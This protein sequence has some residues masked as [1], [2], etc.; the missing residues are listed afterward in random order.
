MIEDK[1]FWHNDITST[2]T[3]TLYQYNNKIQP[4]RN[5]NQHQQSYNNMPVIYL[6]V[7]KPYT[8]RAGKCVTVKVWCENEYEHSKL[9]I[10]RIHTFTPPTEGCI[11]VFRGSKGSENYLTLKNGGT[12]SSAKLKCVDVY[13][14]KYDYKNKPLLFVLH[15]ENGG[16]NGVS[17]KY[18]RMSCF[19]Q[20]K[21]RCKGIDELCDYKNDSDILCALVKESDVLSNVLMYDIMQRPTSNGNTCT[22]NC[23]KIQVTKDTNGQDPKLGTDFKR[24]KHQPGSGAK[25]VTKACVTYLCQA[26]LD[27]G[28]A[29]LD[30]VQGKPY[31]CITVY[32][33][34]KA[35]RA[36]TDKCKAP[37]A[38]ACTQGTGEGSA[39]PSPTS[40]G[41]NTC[42][43]A[44]GDGTTDHQEVPLMIAL[45][46]QSNSDSNNTDY[47][48]H[49]R[50]AK[51]G[52]TGS[53]TDQ[54]YWVK[55][56]NNGHENGLKQLLADIGFQTASN[57]L[58][59]S[60]RVQTMIVPLLKRLEFD[61][62]DSVVI[63]LDKKNGSGGYNDTDIT[64]AIK[65][66]QTGGKN[67]T[68]NLLQLS[69]GDN[70]IKVTYDQNG[71]NK[72]LTKYKY[73]VVEHDF[74]NA[75]KGLVDKCSAGLR[76]LVPRKENGNGGG[77]TKYAQL[78]LYSSAT[79][80]DAQHLEY[81]YYTRVGNGDHTESKVYVVFY[82]GTGDGAG[83]PRPL[84]LCYQ[85]QTYR[86]KDKTGYDEQTWVKVDGVDKLCNG[87]D[88]SNGQNE[89]LLKAVTEVVGFLNRV[90]LQVH[91]GMTKGAGQQCTTGTTSAP[92]ATCQAGTS[93]GSGECKYDVHQFQSYQIKVKVTCSQVNGSN[94]SKCYKKL[95]HQPAGINGDLAS[96]A[97]FRLGD[98]EYCKNGGGG[99]GRTGSIK[100]YQN[101]SNGVQNVSDNNKYSPL[102]AVWAYFYDQDTQYKDPLLVVLM[103]RV[104]RTEA[105][106]CYKLTSSGSGSLA[107][108]KDPNEACKKD[109]PELARHLD[110]IRYCLKYVLK[111]ELQHNGTKGSGYKLEGR[112]A[113]D[114]TPV[115]FNKDI[116][117]TG[118]VNV[119][120]Q[121]CTAL[122]DSGYKCFKHGL[123][124][125][126]KGHQHEVAGLAFTLPGTNG[127]SVGK[128][129]EIPLY[130]GAAGQCTGDAAS[131]KLVGQ[132]VTCTNGPGPAPGPAPGAKI[133]YNQC[134]GDVCVYFYGKGGK[135]GSISENQTD[136]VPLMLRYN[137]QF[138][139]PETRDSYFQKWVCVPT[140]C[141][142]D[143]ECC[144][145][146]S[147]SGGHGTDC[148]KLVTQLNEVNAALNQ[149]D[150][151]PDKSTTGGYG[152]PE[153]GQGGGGH[154]LANE[155][156]NVRV[157]VVTQT[158]GG[159]GAK[160]AYVRVVH[161][162]KNGFQIGDIK[163]NNQDIVEKG[164]TPNGAGGDSG[165]ITVSGGNHQVDV[166]TNRWNTVVVYYSKTD[167]KHQ[168]PQLIVVLK[169][170]NELTNGSGQTVTGPANTAYG[171]YILATQSGVS[172]GSGYEYKWRL[173][174]SQSGGSGVQLDDA[175]DF[176]LLN[177][178]VI[179][180]ERRDK[181]GGSY[182]DEQLKTA[183]ASAI[184]NKSLNESPGNSKDVNRLQDKNIKVT[185][186]TGTGGGSV[187]HQCLNNTGFKVM[188]HDL[189]NLVKLN[190][191]F[192]GTLSTVALITGLKL[193]IPTNEK[194]K[195]KQ[196]KLVDNGSKDATDDKGS[197]MYH[198]SKNDKIYVFFYGSDPRPLLV[199]YDNWAYSPKTLNG[200]F[201]DWHK[202]EGV[203]KCGCDQTP[204]PKTCDKCPVV[205][206]LVRVS[207]F[208][209]PVK[210]QVLPSKTKPYTIHWFNTQPIRIKV[211][212]QKAT[213]KFCYNRYTHSHA[214]IRG[215]GKGFRLG[216][217][218]HGKEC[219]KENGTK[220]P[221]NGK[222]I[223]ASD[224]DDPKKLHR[225]S[226]EVVVFYYKGDKNHRNPLLVALRQPDPD[227]TWDKRHK[228][229]FELQKKVDPKEQKE[230]TRG[231][232]PQD[233]KLADTSPEG[234]LARTLDS[235]LFNISQKLRVV[236]STRPVARP[237]SAT[238]AYQENAVTLKEFRETKQKDLARVA[239][240]AAKAAEEAK[241][242]GGTKGILTDPQAIK[243]SLTHHVLRETQYQAQL[244]EAGGT[245]AVSSSPS[246]LKITIR[247]VDCSTIYSQGGYR[248]FRHLLTT[249]TGIDQVGGLKLAVFEGQGGQV[250]GGGQ[251]EITLCTGNGTA[252]PQPVELRYTT[253]K[254][255]LFV[256]FYDEDPRPL[257]L[258]YDSGAYCP[259]D[260]AGYCR[261]WVRVNDSASGTTTS[262][263]C[264]DPKIGDPKV[265]TA[266][267]D[268]SQFM[269]PVRLCLT[270]E[271]YKK[272]D[273]EHGQDSQ[274]EAQ[275]G[276][277]A[278][279]GQ[280]EKAKHHSYIIHK[281]SQPPVCV[282]VTGI[283]LRCY[284]Q[285]VHQPEKHG[286]RLGQV[287]YASAEDGGAAKP[288]QNGTCTAS[289]TPGPAGPAGTTGDAC[290][291]AAPG[292][293]S[294][295]TNGFCFEY[296]SSKQLLSVC[297]YYYMY[298]SGHKWPLVVELG[299]KR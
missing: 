297:V 1:L 125:A 54:Y 162:T 201:T 60:S 184:Q 206:E 13:F 166:S 264:A 185:D 129:I 255:D 134:M 67:G 95:I 229:Y 151:C 69:N 20:D 93:N 128:V 32:F 195:Y 22:Y 276:P 167:S 2:S 174:N 173:V 80:T 90:Q 100:Y 101:G 269:N 295:T 61:L 45:Q 199:C 112:N 6:Y 103:F 66:Q 236:L 43:A 110:E 122:S 231:T 74:A 87:D 113:K 156:G 154:K 222:C 235:I 119:T 286:F 186:E 219:I 11:Y 99:S 214:G 240:E 246:N 83:D 34:G 175:T 132:D 192:G 58:G 17:N 68:I 131:Q 89:P 180:L 146:V 51:N 76:F 284:K 53:N 37:G 170:D 213:D 252:D 127:G 102:V 225:A 191:Q 249:A 296:D 73:R 217:I 176:R 85:G 203:T 135:T 84:L 23:G 238:G 48:V 153:N 239:D 288:A 250:G 72:C 280:S 160:N 299:F 29:E 109:G 92:G 107:W 193:L 233:L 52:V 42:P 142:V 266:L 260:M 196:V 152:L 155:V 290:S 234:E 139:R 40:G 15:F 19:D 165:K 194:D 30:K 287:T 281:E 147:G 41:G 227:T 14:N 274:P 273:P 126:L 204:L 47:Y 123:T 245:Q 98:V 56:G 224:V 258:C 39:C 77:D 188:T 9:F 82:N 120:V 178:G 212:E 28:K 208:L 237:Y 279:S 298:D 228:P 136:T 243:S 197:I 148:S 150:L 117:G 259:R 62:T 278:T 169:T 262:S 270:E 4:T 78:K 253:C 294:T 137:K 133:T 143:K 8:Y 86:P 251:G 157:K 59:T 210:L 159:D 118:T 5:H 248:C 285:Y 223:S 291:P 25:G 94:G 65:T 283:D 221:S 218:Y 64:R 124:E 202:A 105:K 232:K 10:K 257:L 145:S 3:H 268:V 55:L 106:E 179:L 216:N 115:Q 275:P 31:S 254:G 158:P 81:K 261:E 263:G 88:T 108:A 241:A 35:K 183:I 57:G 114:G 33:G 267:Y 187:T 172:N 226:P 144:C 292:T 36:C 104:S 293:P 247:E 265:L 27:S 121:E 16:R 44:P 205:S 79:E 38:K 12:Y 116:N 181:S 161:R 49:R 211:E 207:D 256:F 18:Y 272:L 141:T 189:D 282:R 198:Q 7:R 140:L 182:G 91:P 230:Y 111:V 24:Y 130:S 200:Y 168:L 277:V 215:N 271:A 63:L 289:Q 96:N 149:I 46:K 177:A 242:S 138:Y 190:G 70:K 209:N 71:N 75:V 26:L 21:G 171:Y 97:N 244:F 163:Y 164:I 220:T 50:K